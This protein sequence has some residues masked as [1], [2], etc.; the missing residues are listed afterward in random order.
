M[1]DKNIAQ[2][3]A[4]LR[5]QI[6][7]LAASNTAAREKL[8][9]LLSDLEDNIHSLEDSEHQVHLVGD[10]RE[11]IAEFEVEHPRL[12][13]ILNDIMVALSNLGI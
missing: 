4:D 1:T 2:S 8:E 12:T 11:A 7:Q 10:L 9:G 3:L 5:T 6:D 13:G